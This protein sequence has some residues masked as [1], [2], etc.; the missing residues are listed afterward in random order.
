MRDEHIITMVACKGGWPC[1]EL[2]CARMFVLF[3]CAFFAL[4]PSRVAA[5]SG[6]LPIY[7]MDV[8]YVIEESGSYIVAEYVSAT[9][10]IGS[11]IIV[12]ADDVTLDLGG[13]LVGGTLLGT[14]I[15]QSP[16]NHN[17]V[18]KNGTVLRGIDAD[19]SGNRFE[20][21]S[22]YLGLADALA[23]GPGSVVAHCVLA[24]N[25]LDGSGALIRVGDGSRVSDCSLVYNTGVGN[26]R[27][28]VGGNGVT[29][30]RCLLSEGFPTNLSSSVIAIEVGDG[31]VIDDIAI[32]DFAAEAWSNTI[33][34]KAGRD[35]ILTDSLIVGPVEVGDGS[36][37]SGC[38][39]NDDWNSFVA[40]SHYDSTMGDGSVVTH[41]RIRGEFA[42]RIYINDG[43]L[44]LENYCWDE[45][46]GGNGSMIAK[47]YSYDAIYVSY[48]CF[49]ADNFVYSGILM[50][51]SCNRIDG[52]RLQPYA[53]GGTGYVYYAIQAYGSDDLV[54]RNRYAIDSTDF[55]NGGSGDHVGERVDQT[56]IS[57]D[58]PWANVECD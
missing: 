42:S 13:N 18:V 33:A 26:F 47:N 56:V 4:A 30:E 3:G 46:H 8:P 6:L 45:I 19:G 55:M 41:N 52:N 25:T 5:Q 48:D 38:D 34:V 10:L 20:N 54:V 27:G 17:L 58:Q 40:D 11:A 1:L 9:N 57:S 37:V 28:I 49:V 35:T 50:E 7:Q 36:L 24:S 16:S 43:S 29:I 15:Y 39:I 12:S 14:A 31:C 53:Q 44:M 21:L 22:L 2:L 32:N 23:T 51:N